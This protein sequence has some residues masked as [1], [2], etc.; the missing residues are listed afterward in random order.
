VVLVVMG[1]LSI[2]VTRKSQASGVAAGDGSGHPH[3]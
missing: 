3:A 1:V 2:G